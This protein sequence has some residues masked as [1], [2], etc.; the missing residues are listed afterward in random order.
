MQFKIELRW[1]GS[2]LAYLFDRPLSPGLDR[3]KI[4]EFSTAISSTGSG[5][6][7][8]TT[9]TF[10]FTLVPTSAGLGTVQS[11]EISYLVWPDSIPGQL[12]TEPMT[13]MISSPILKE[14]SDSG[15]STWLIVLGCFA[16]LVVGVY[17]YRH[18]RKRNQPLAVRTPVEDFLMGL[19]VL[20]GESGQ[21]MKKLQ[22]GLSEL[23]LAY[24]EQQYQITAAE[25]SDDDLASALENTDLSPGRQKALAQWLS[26]A[27]KDKFRPVASTLGDTIR[28]EQAVRTFFEKIHNNDNTE[29]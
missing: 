5:D 16:V 17:A 6:T 28:L 26:S 24:L 3:L 4:R 12:L 8:V 20:K 13:V 1:D 9:K 18:F 27:R 25:M 21:D 14:E 29:D 23:L 11:V 10:S 2:Q 22:S 19:R 7:E 15:F